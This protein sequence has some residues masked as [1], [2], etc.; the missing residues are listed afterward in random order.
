MSVR[1]V[2][3]TIILLLGGTA[4]FIVGNP[5]YRLWPTNW[6]QT[7]YGGLTGFFLAAGLAFRMIP[8]FRKYWKTA[9]AFMV[10]SAAL[11]VLKA[12]FFNLSIPA[13]NDLQD[14][15]FDKLSQFLHITPVILFLTL[16]R[17]RNLGNVF[18]KKGNLK[19]TLRF[20]LIWF[21]V[22]A[23]AGVVI[24]WSSGEYFVNLI[25]RNWPYAL[26]FIFA[27]SVMEELWF[28]GIFLREFNEL[29][30]KWGAIIV[31]AA[32]FGASHISA[33]YFFPGGGLIYGLVVAGLGAVGAYA[34]LK[35]DS[36][37]GPILFHAGYDIM[38]LVPV[39]L[40]M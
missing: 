5:Y 21:V 11:V 2:L 1:K 3:T 7:Y 15:S 37:I 14:L 20:G 9:Y 23:V 12:G 26:M 35:D 19:A 18:L 6:N 29:I 16:V 28:R 31:T 17:T 8:S 40:S 25:F 13:S 4:V 33:T 34:A 39:L 10:A 24:A 38:I 22:F 27:N 30:G 36:L 32:I